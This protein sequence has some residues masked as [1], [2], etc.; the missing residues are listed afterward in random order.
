MR[1]LTHWRQLV[2]VVFGFLAVVALCCVGLELAGVPVLEPIGLDEL[3]TRHEQTTPSH[4][5]V[6][7]EGTH[8]DSDS[9]AAPATSP[10]R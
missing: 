8:A 1:L 5:V 7:G 3:F 9:T 6:E 4:V 2:L 10:P